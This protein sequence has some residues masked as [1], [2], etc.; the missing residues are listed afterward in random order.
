MNYYRYT[1]NKNIKDELRENDI[2][3]PDSST[4]QNLPL[5][6]SSRICAYQEKR[7]RNEP[8]K[9]NTKLQRFEGG[10]GG[11]SNHSSY[12][13]QHTVRK[14][15]SVLRSLTQLLVGV[16]VSH[17]VGFHN[18]VHP[19]GTVL[20]VLDVLLLDRGAFLRLVLT[21]QPADASPE[22]V[23]LEPDLIDHGLELFHDRLCLDQ[24]VSAHKLL[25][26]QR[27]D[28]VPHVPQRA[29]CTIEKTRSSNL[30][31]RVT[32]VQIKSSGTVGI[33]T[34]GPSVKLICLMVPTSPSPW[35]NSMFLTEENMS[36]GQMLW[37]SRIRALN[38]RAG[39][40][41]VLNEWWSVVTAIVPRES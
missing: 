1:G 3:S 15:V 26:V 31:F 14:E 29:C 11:V 41:C 25:L 18:L 39:A 4:S 34:D 37:E 38:M 19:D 36:L 30:G 5:H 13:I 21:G 40:T 8:N 22:A 6:Q 10:G 17:E 35:M 33:T 7:E 24:G 27:V 9:S 32:S 16:G 12:T 23:G 2:W 28:P 20:A